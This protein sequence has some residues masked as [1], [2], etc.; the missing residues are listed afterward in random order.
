MTALSKFLVLLVIFLLANLG[1]TFMNLSSAAGNL[2]PLNLWIWFVEPM[3]KPTKEPTGKPTKRT[4]LPNILTSKRGKYSLLEKQDAELPSKITVSITPFSSD[5]FYT[6]EAVHGVSH[7][8]VKYIVTGQMTFSDGWDNEIQSICPDESLPWPNEWQM[9]DKINLNSSGLRQSTWTEVLRQRD[10][11]YSHSTL[12]KLKQKFK[13]CMLG[14]VESATMATGLSLG[15]DKRFVLS[16]NGIRLPWGR[17]SLPDSTCT[18][19]HRIR[20]HILIVMRYRIGRHLG[21]SSALFL[22]DSW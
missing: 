1:D 7:V 17:Y 3:S 2:V 5:T 19:V 12:K 18:F 22:W 14:S 11:V 4:E 21:L 16:I 6:F 20:I 9:P 15:L 10:K 8:H 13:T